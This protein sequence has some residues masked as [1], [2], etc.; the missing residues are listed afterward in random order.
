MSHGHSDP[1]HHPEVQMA[2]NRNYITGFVVSSLLMLA[3]TILVKDH[4][5]PSFGLLL[6][7]IGC[8]GIAIIAQVYFLLHIDI[9]EHNIW[10]TVALVM[11]IPL[12]IITIGLTWWM[13]SQLYM[14]TMPM[15]P[16]MPGMH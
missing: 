7:I 6:A 5:L 13:F 8:A 16:G 2:T 4:V 9:S 3:A 1:I 15:M 11:F 14:R 12:F 10:N